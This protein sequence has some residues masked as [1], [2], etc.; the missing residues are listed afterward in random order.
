M[1]NNV[2]RRSFSYKIYMIQDASNLIQRY[3]YVT[4]AM[5]NARNAQWKAIHMLQRSSH[6]PNSKNQTNTK[7]PPQTNESCLI[8]CGYMDQ[9]ED[10]VWFE[11]RWMVAS[12]CDERLTTLCGLILG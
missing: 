11:D 8:M 1:V 6:T 3:L 10:H 7:L 2:Y 4:Y 12:L 9:S 5:L